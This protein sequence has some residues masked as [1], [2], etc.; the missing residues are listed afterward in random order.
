MDWLGDEGVSHSSALTSL[1]SYSEDESI[2]HFRK[3][4]NGFPKLQV[5]EK[6]QRGET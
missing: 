4:F 6:G 2:R 3:V 1:S 5:L